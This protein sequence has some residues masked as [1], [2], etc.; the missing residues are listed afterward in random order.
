MFVST[1]DCYEK[2][3]NGRIVGSITDARQPASPVSDCARM[4]RTSGRF[5]PVADPDRVQ[6]FSSREQNV[7]FFVDMLVQVT[8]QILQTVKHRAPRVAGVSRHQKV[9]CQLS[10]SFQCVTG[11]VVFVFHHADWV[12]D[13]AKR[14]SGTLL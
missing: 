2:S 11:V 12:A 14:K 4:K 7:V 6:L 9:S 10:N 1:T 5:T 13:G 3:S 8:F